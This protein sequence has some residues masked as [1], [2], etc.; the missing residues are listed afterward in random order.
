MECLDS[1]ELLFIIMLFNL[2][3]M[4]IIELNL[5][6]ILLA[7]PLCICAHIYWE[8]GNG[9]FLTFILDILGC[10]EHLIAWF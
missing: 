6:L 1:K 2:D 7:L 9:E 10:N 5:L 3:Y 8:S 4:C